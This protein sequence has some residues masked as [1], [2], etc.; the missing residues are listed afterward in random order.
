MLPAPSVRASAPYRIMGDRAWDSRVRV[1]D[2]AEHSIDFKRCKWEFLI[3]A[4]VYCELLM[5]FYCVFSVQCLKDLTET[6]LK[7]ETGM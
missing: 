1:Y 2:G 4:K 7:N 3:T 5:N 6:P